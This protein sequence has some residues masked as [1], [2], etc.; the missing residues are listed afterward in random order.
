VKRRKRMSGRDLNIWI[1]GEVREEEGSLKGMI[2]S[3]DSC[4]LSVTVRSRSLF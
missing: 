3:V 2:H 4:R 1:S